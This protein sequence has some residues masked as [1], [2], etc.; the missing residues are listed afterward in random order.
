M[1]DLQDGHAMTI[2]AQESFLPMVKKTKKIALIQ[3]E[4][5]PSELFQDAAFG[6]SQSRFHGSMATRAV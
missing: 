2:F 6:L 3:K 4:T 1:R 5:P